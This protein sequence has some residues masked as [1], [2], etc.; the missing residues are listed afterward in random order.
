[1]DIDKYKRF[2]PVVEA[3]AGRS[4]YPGTKVGALILGE[5]FEP[6]SFGWNGAPRGSKADEDGRLE[7]RETR[8]NWACH[9]EAN[10]VANAAATGTRLLGGTMLVTLMPCTSCAKL[11]IQAGIKV[12][13]CP[14]PEGD[15]ADRW[16]HEFSITRDMFV[17]TGVELVE[18]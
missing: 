6:L 4:K 18:I 1:M 7:D 11:A 2:W 15:V 10:A 5:R 3:V 13:I 12:V 9:A 14:K 8:L 17:E 16:A